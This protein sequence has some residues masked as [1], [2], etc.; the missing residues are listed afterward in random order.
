MMSFRYSSGLIVGKF[1]PL[2]LGHEQLINQAIAQ[3]ETVYLISYS[4][5]EFSKCER[6]QRERWLNLR[7]PE[8]RSVVLD[9]S[10]LSDFVNSEDWPCL[11]SNC[12]SAEVH[13]KLCAELCLMHFQTAVDAVFSSEEYGAGFALYLSEAFSEYYHRE[14]KVV[15]VCEDPERL[16]L[17]ISGTE[18]RS[19]PHGNRQ[20]LSGEVY[21]DFVDKVCFLGGESTGKSQLSRLA[22]QLFETEFVAEYG[23]A[24]WDAQGGVLH[25]PDMLKIAQVQVQQEEQACLMANRYL[26]CDTS[27]LTTLFYSHEMFG[28]VDPALEDLAKRT[29][30]YVFLC[31]PDFD[32]VQDGTRR[33]DAF[34]RLQHAWYLR[35]LKLREIPFIRLYGTID[36]RLRDIE[37]V[38]C[39]AVFVDAD[40]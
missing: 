8:V 13:R 29:Y 34:R 17:P 35:E 30:E 37:S 5:P 38:L 18:I 24:L 28:E 25:E 12:A 32:F 20:Y 9:D 19:D 15:N 16:L 7:F 31:E 6:E 11:P 2:H 1:S 39:D 3:C 33:D 22:A 14:I 36:N 40:T 4:K 27:P 10:N 21:R 26:F 23:R